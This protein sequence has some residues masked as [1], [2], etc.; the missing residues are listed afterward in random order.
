MSTPNETL[1]V[2]VE[3]DETLIEAITPFDYRFNGTS[4]FTLP[5]FDAP[6]RDDH[7]SI[8]LIVG[9]SGTGKS[10]LLKK[11]YGITA[12]PQWVANKSIASQV[13][14]QTLSAVGL[15]SVPSWCRPYH[16]LSNGEQ[17]RARMAAMLGSNTAFDEFTSVVDRTIAKSCSYAIQRKIR[18][19][20]L[21]GIVFATCHY[22]VVEWLQPDWVFDTL[23]SSATM[24]R[25]LWR[26]PAITISI[27]RCESNWWSVF[28]N[29]H[30]L[31]EE[32]N[33]SSHCYLAKWNENV[34]GFASVLSMPSGTIKNAWRG[35][36]VVVLPDYQGI[37]IGV[38]LSDAIAQMYVDQ[39]ARYFSKTA[40]PRMGGYRN[41]SKLWKPTTK[42]M[43]KRPD[44]EGRDN[45]KYRR[46]QEHSNRFCYSHEYIGQAD[47][48][49]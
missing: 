38:R 7:W 45:T 40:H 34:V 21:T 46:L 8:G 14:Y 35:H 9:P 24:G 4:T 42:N 47:A 11:H 39:G 15:N 32:L 5:K 18:C 20:K 48:V 3:V 31:N 6:K 41:Q 16:V 2:S 44:Y 19:D 22:D 27:E 23:T 33:R 12:E 25:S 17:F 37:G 49:R 30:Y 13:P 1:S 36:R 10:H 29:H 26:R 43:M 28:K